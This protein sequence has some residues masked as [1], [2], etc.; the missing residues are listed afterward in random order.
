MDMNR[1]KTKQNQAVERL[2]A[3]LPLLADGLDAAKMRLLKER[4]CEQ[5]GCSER[6]LRRYMNAYRQNGLA[7]LEPKSRTQFGK[8]AVIPQSLLEQA[9]LLRREVPGR[10]VAQIIQILEWEGLAK[11]GELKRSTLQDRLIRSGYGSRQMRLYASTG[12]AAR[13]FQHKERNQLWQADI[14]YGPYLPIGGGGAN[15]Q[16]YLVAF[17][18]DA[19]RYVLHAAFYP[20]LDK[21]IVEHCFRHAIECHG[22]PD[23]VY[24]D[25]G[26]Q[27]RT[28]SMARTCAKLGIRLRFTR[29]YAAESKGK[30]ERF[31][32]SVDSFLQELRLE[33]AR[34]LD[35]L[36]TLFQVWLSECYQTK[37]HAALS[38]GQSPEAAFRSGRNALRFVDDSVIGD[39]FLQSERRKVDKSG[40]I[41]LFGVKYE[42]GL[43]FI[44]RQVEVVYD[45]QD[46]SAVT[47]EMEGHAP[48]QVSPLVIG[49]R[50]G[51]RPPLPESMLEVPATHSRLIRAAQ[52]RHGERKERQQRAMSFRQLSQPKEGERDV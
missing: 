26:K 3:V 29:P 47:I 38:D 30:I 10:S 6:T 1:T 4:I 39:A 31:N 34:T 21:R 19:T 25:N 11:P 36:N 15:K 7:G 24:F 8:K 9:I 23:A 43:V 35:Q 16:V 20:T 32:R 40:C 37:P 51:T 5:Y 45:T 14:K 44:G 12:V 42:V 2:Q 48:F 13:R 49:E 28:H 17:I 41:S 22:I 33:Q 46:V 50:A 18:D 27:F 52:S